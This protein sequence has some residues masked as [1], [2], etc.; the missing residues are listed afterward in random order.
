ML[1]FKHI[2][3]TAGNSIKEVLLDDILFLGHD[4]YGLGYKHLYYH[5][6]K[7][8]RSFVFSVVRNPYD[9]AVSAFFY[10]NKGGNN[11][12]D[13]FDRI[14]Y[15]ERYHKWIY[16]NKTALCNIAYRFENIIQCEDFPHKNKSNR[17]PYQHY[18]NK[19]TKDIIFKHY[20][21]DFELF[22]YDK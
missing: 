10:L 7:Y 11:P 6:K 4:F 18:Y 20:Q 22:G 1:I 3:R 16:Y 9:R 13:E 2:P 12:L 5:I 15:I 8:T 17:K 21:K 14:R 19:T